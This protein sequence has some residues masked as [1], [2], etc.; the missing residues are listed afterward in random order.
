MPFFISQPISEISEAIRSRQKEREQAGL[1]RILIHTDAA[2]AIGKI[3]VDVTDL[4]VDYLTIV[5]HKFYAPRIGKQIRNHV[6]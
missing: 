3:K 4:C 2:Q 1:P 6:H 5:G